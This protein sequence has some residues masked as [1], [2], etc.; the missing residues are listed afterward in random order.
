MIAAGGAFEQRN[1]I[2]L[3]TYDRPIVRCNLAPD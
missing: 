1:R 3:G 2:G